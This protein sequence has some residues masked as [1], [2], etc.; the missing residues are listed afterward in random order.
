MATYKKGFKKEN[1]ETVLLKVIIG[2]IVV[3]FLM[4]GVLFIY[5]ATTGWKDYS[6]F[7]TTTTYA[8]MFEYTNGEE[9]A[10]EDYV[11]YMYSTN[12]SSVAIKTDVLRDGK[13]INKDSEMFFLA[14]S[15]AMSDSD[16]ELADFLATIDEDALSTPMLIVVAN[17]EFY[18]AYIGS[19]DLLAALDSI[20]AGTFDAF[21]D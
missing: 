3:V 21:N 18:E 12:E 14:N 1:P 4:V 5:D 8:D 19:V 13:K 7:T 17:G 6:Y 9:T 15:T 2:I 20:E 16:T 10:L 11:I